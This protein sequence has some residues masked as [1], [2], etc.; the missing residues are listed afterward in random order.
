RLDPRRVAHAAGVALEPGDRLDQPLTLGQ[1]ADQAPVQGVQPGAQAGEG[2]AGLGVRTHD[3]TPPRWRP[4]P[5]CREPETNGP[6]GPA[7]PTR[8]ASSAASMRPSAKARNAS[9]T[10]TMSAVWGDSLRAPTPASRSRAGGA[11]ASWTPCDRVWTP[12]T[13]RKSRP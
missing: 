1:P 7:S 4:A 2:Q 13:A 11:S 3:A 12:L 5:A 8:A 6:G 10:A 9:A